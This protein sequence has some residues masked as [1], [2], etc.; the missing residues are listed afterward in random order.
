MR[1]L[2]G[3]G[4]NPGIIICSRQSARRKPAFE[5]AGSSLMETGLPLIF[6]RP[7]AIMG[8]RKVTFGPAAK[9]GEE[10]LPGAAELSPERLRGSGHP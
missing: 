10:Q 8:E 9:D 3:R 1:R 6:G 4:C 7:A 5:S 2:S